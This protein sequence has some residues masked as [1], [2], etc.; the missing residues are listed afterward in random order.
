MNRFLIIFFL[1][2]ISEVSFGQILGGIMNSAKRKLERKIED[3]IVEAVSDELARRAFKPI[4]EAID[5]MMRQKYQDSINQGKEVDWDKM[6]QSYAEFLNGMNK[7][8]DLPEKYTFDIT[9]EVEV[10]DYS[11][12][13]NYL[14][15]HYSKTDAVIGMENVDDVESNQFV[16][17][18]IS[19]DA[20]VLFT[21]D[22]KGKKSAQ[23]IPSIMKLAGT[24]A[25]SAK[26]D[27]IETKN[28]FKIEKTG[29][30]KKIAGYQ[31]QEYKGNTKE[32]E[33]IMYVSENFP[34]QWQKSYTSY[35]NKFAPASYAENTS[36]IESGIM[37]E[38]EN[39]RKDEDKKTT[40]ITKK[41]AEKSFEILKSDY[42][43]EK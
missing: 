38:Y 30:K 27:G 19:R 25:T 43:F 31:S 4:D 3:K 5:S 17:M 32:E 41:V 26:T 2:I 10:V 18:D 13:T 29:K 8:V 14:K 6:G 42:N 36:G 34:V 33:M 15:L 24:L 40:W 7:A 39:S 22:K 23:V 21:T 1:M 12:K 11:N 16:V 20:M 35:M 28:D 9:Q 37:L